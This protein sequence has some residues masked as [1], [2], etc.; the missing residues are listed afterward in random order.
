MAQRAEF[1]SIIDGREPT[2][3]TSFRP[4]SSELAK[5][6]ENAPLFYAQHPLHIPG[7]GVVS[8]ILTAYAKVLKEGDY[9]EA[10]DI[11]HA[12]QVRDLSEEQRIF[13]TAL[14]DFGFLDQTIFGR[15]DSVR[16]VGVDDVVIEGMSLE[17]VYGQKRSNYRAQLLDD[18]GRPGRR[19][20]AFRRRKNDTETVGLMLAV[21][22]TPAHLNEITANIKWGTPDTVRPDPTDHLF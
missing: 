5:F 12:K 15:D 1:P 13:P 2:A 9:P 8:G 22:F 18:M 16:R 10:F 11:S 21:P 17:L 14:L 19:F 3:S 6:N 7:T 20:G 4:Y